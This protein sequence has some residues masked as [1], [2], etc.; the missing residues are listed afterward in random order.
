MASRIKKILLVLLLIV[1]IAGIYFLAKYT[2]AF[3]YTPEYR[4]LTDSELRRVEEIRTSAYAYAVRCSG[5]TTPALQF[6]EIN[7]MLVPGNELV[8]P[9]IEGR[10]VKLK[11]WFN[12]RDSTIY[13]PFTERET[14][15]IT[16]HESMHAIG[17]LGHPHIPFRTCNL[18]ADQ[19]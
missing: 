2:D 15:W 9:T 7:W 18:M 3:R 1:G 16:A 8:I 13:I 4:Q 11:G 12:P 19:N 5:I 17:Y 10:N 6:N 14:F